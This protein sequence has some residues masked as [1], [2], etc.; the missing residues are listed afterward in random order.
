MSSRN[1]TLEDFEYV[2]DLFRSGKIQAE[3]FISHRFT[4]NQVLGIFTKINEPTEQVIKSM[5]TL[6]E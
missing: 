5:I 1:A 4:K 3:K 6:A 2:M